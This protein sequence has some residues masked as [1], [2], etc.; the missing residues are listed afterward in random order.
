MALYKLSELDDWTLV[1][2][3]QD[4]RGWEVRD[5]A[6]NRIGKV[7]DLLVNRATERVERIRLEDGQE[8]PAADINIGDGVVYASGEVPTSV[9]V[10]GDAPV[11]ASALVE[12]YDTFHE[13]FR[14]HCATTYG[15]DSKYDEYQTAYRYGYNLATDPN[16]RDRNYEEIE[17]DVRQAYDTRYGTGAY[18]R[19]S[20]ATRYAYD[21][22]CAACTTE[23]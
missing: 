21:R 3:D 7:D 9:R 20:P 17:P 5:A 22:T 23:A 13:D 16:Y 14:S 4:I 2:D 8:V 18:D 10:Y 11:R 1:Y 12:P 15:D 19:A 6:E